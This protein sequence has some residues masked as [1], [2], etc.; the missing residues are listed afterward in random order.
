MQEN[1]REIYIKPDLIQI[2][3]YEKDNF[4]EVH[5]TDIDFKNHVLKVKYGQIDSYFCLIKVKLIEEKE[6][7]V[8]I[9]SANTLLN[10][11]KERVKN[12]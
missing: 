8:L 11:S 6:N 5:I 12:K 2:Q 7:F 4:Y 3:N 10:I 1:N 9:D